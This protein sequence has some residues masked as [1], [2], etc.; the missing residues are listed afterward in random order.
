MCDVKFLCL[1]PEAVGWDIFMSKYDA[2]IPVSGI[3]V[4]VSPTT[5]ALGK[6]NHYKFRSQIFRNQH[7]HILH[8]VVFIIILSIILRN[9]D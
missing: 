8:H 4:T 3:A 1:V 7:A 5:V 9:N 2:P 6:I